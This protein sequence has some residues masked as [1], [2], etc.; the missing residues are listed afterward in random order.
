MFMKMTTNSIVNKFYSPSLIV[1]GSRL[2]T[3]TTGTTICHQG[4][5]TGHACGTVSSST[6]KP[7]W[8]GACPSTCNSAF[9]AFNA[10]QT[11]GDSGGSVFYGNQPMAIHKGGTSTLSVASWLKYGPS[12]VS[13]Y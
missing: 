2:D 4:R 12:A 13:L 10:A 6:Y 7:T 9:L 5:V 8:A 1:R 3:I 11:G